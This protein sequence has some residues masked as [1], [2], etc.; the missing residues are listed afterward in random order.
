M[1]DRQAPYPLRFRVLGFRVLGFRYDVLP[2]GMY[3]I[4]R[5]HKLHQALISLK[6]GGAEERL[7]AYGRI[8][9]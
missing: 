2:I 9:E 1:L 7:C 4:R 6:A 8:N 5:P 3:D